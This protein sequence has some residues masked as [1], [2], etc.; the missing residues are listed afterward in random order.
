MLNLSIAMIQVWFFALWF[1]LQTGN[2]VSITAPVD[3]EILKD[4][5]PIMGN[6]AVDGYQRYEITFAYAGDQTGTWFWLD[7]SSDVVS[8]SQLALWDTK[9]ITDGD[10]DLR[11]QVFLMDDSVLEVIVRDLKVRNYSDTPTSP[12]VLG[13]SSALPLPDATL[14]PATE[15]SKPGEKATL[16]PASPVSAMESLTENP[17]TLTESS[18]YSILRIAGILT[19]MVFALLGFILYMRHS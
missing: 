7:S 19:V 6:T 9:V 17:A 3:G 4:V 13:Q 12:A 14:I 18:I 5:V 1:L 2:P 11:L 15:L 16:V 8:Q 10:Y